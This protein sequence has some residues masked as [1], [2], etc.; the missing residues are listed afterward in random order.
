LYQ[1]FGNQSP[2][3]QGHRGCDRMEVGFTTTCALSAYHHWCSEFE[4]RS[5]RGVQHYVIKFVSDLRQ[6]SGFL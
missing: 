6:V 2:N 1:V 3:K 4:S 5:G